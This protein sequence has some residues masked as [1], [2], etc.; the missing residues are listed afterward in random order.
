[1]IKPNVQTQSNN[2][3]LIKFVQD[4]AKIVADSNTVNIPINNNSNDKKNMR[5]RVAYYN[6]QKER[7]SFVAMIFGGLGLFLMILENEFIMNEVYDMASNFP[8][9]LKTCKI[10]NLYEIKGV[11]WIICCQRPNFSFNIIF[12]SLNMLLPYD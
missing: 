3:N 12:T 9:I 7:A 1:M 10:T 4:T 6:K 5:T 2:N 11:C 8:L